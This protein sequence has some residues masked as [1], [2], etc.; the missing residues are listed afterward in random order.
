MIDVGRAF[1]VAS[2]ERLVELISEARRRLVVISPALTDE[3]A[4][5]LA[6]RL[7]DL[8]NISI[9]V[10]VD[11]DPEVYRLGFGTETALDRLRE[12]SDPN[13]FDLRVQSGVRIGVVISDEIT[14]IFSPVP[15]LIEAGSTSVEKPN[16]I[17]LAGAATS[18]RLANAAGA[19]PTEAD[20]TQEI[21]TQALTPAA[22]MAV[23]QDLKA[24]PPQSFDVARALRIFSSKVQYVELEAENYRFSSRKVPLPPELLS[25][26]DDALKSQI[27]SRIRAPAEG[28]GK[29]KIT[30]G[31]SEKIE[32]I[33][34]DE[35][36]IDSERKRIEDTYTYTVPRFGRIILSA[37]RK[38]FDVEMNRFKQILES[39]HKAILAAVEGVK[40]DFETRLV[41]E[42]LP[43]W[44]ERPPA[45]FARYGLEPTDSNLE[46]QLRNVTQGLLLKAISFE[47]PRVRVIYK[48]VAP[49]SVRDPSFL[50][51]LKKIMDRRGVPISIIESLFASGDAAPARDGFRTPP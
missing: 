48:N 49:E 23:K 19:G 28:L 3:V 20:V 1:A 38:A 15:L 18:D 16:A 7:P 44:R 2:E 32:T 35:K 34:V 37:D 41:N 12:A 29:L 46:H 21:G 26:V 13:M 33:E 9:T 42:F 6:A 50:D 22:I 51:P 30:I 40:T 8:G 5:A 47:P 45:N 36:W 39:Y 24:N 14:M 43:K 11:A 27:S 10:I 4:A 17:V 31:A 25:V